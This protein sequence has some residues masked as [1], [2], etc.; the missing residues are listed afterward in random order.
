MHKTSSSQILGYSFG[1][2]FVMEVAALAILFFARR[3]SSLKTIRGTLHAFSSKALLAFPGAVAVDLLMPTT[4]LIRWQPFL[5]VIG[6]AA[7]WVFFEIWAT[8]DQ[9]L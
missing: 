6:A 4:S 8:L 7:C 3:D 9:S 5:F 2:L 1:F